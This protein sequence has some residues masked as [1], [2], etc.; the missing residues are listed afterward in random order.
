[1]KK[2]IG[3]IVTSLRAKLSIAP[4]KVSETEKLIEA[5]KQELRQNKTHHKSWE[6]N[7]LCR[8]LMIELRKCI[9]EGKNFDIDV[10]GEVYRL[11]STCSGSQPVADNT[12]LAF[13]VID[14]PTLTSVHN[15]WGLG[16][17]VDYGDEK[18]EGE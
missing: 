15:N 18:L 17:A 8:P 12:V 9:R 7:S 10:D 11:M 16:G 1:M 2:L 6:H 5:V 3:T 14:N 13:T 4:P